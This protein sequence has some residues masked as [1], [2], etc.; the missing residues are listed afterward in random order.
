MELVEYC[1]ESKKQNG[2]KCTSCFPS[3]LCGQ[4]RAEAHCCCP[5]SWERIMLHIAR[6]GKDQNSKFKIWF[7]LNKYCFHT[8]VKP[9][10]LKSKH[11]KLGIT[12]R[13]S[14]SKL[15]DK[16]EEGILNAA[17]ETKKMEHMEERVRNTEYRIEISH[18]NLIRVS[19]RQNR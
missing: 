5:I 7:L 19:E 6:L 13:H 8:I 11:G 16:S 3:W 18:T 1:T 2:C 14:W 4:L 17:Q 9:K 15:K 12:C 10:N